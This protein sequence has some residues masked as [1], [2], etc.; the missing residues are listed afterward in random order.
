MRKNPKMQRTRGR[1]AFCKIILLA[2][3]SNTIKNGSHIYIMNTERTGY[4]DTGLAFHP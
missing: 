3:S 1:A 2:D 4:E